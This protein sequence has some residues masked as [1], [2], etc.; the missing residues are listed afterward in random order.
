MR[1]AVAVSSEQMSLAG[2]VTV[3]AM[4]GSPF[5]ASFFTSARWASVIFKP[6]ALMRTRSYLPI[7]SMFSASTSSRLMRALSLALAMCPEVRGWKLT[8]AMRV[9]PNHVRHAKETAMMK[10]R[11]PT[12]PIHNRRDRR[13]DW[14]FDIGDIDVGD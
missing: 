12:K 13:N 10:K 14:N 5:S 6:M 3:S 8:K 1:A 9:V 7:F 11:S 2:L 4:T